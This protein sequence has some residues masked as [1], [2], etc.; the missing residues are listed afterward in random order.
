[1]RGLEGFTKLT[2]FSFILFRYE[3]VNKN[4]FSWI[5]WVSCDGSLVNN[6][7]L[8]QFTNQHKTNAA[9]PPSHNLTS[10]DKLLR[11]TSSSDEDA[12]SGART[13]SRVTLLIK[14]AG[15]GPDAR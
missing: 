8:H 4:V 10:W 2:A 15:D 13:Q 1:M 11:D 14:E 12:R 3:T 6:L 7:I 9:R 5:V